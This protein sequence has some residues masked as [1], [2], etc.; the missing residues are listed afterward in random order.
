MCPPFIWTGE[1]PI[2]A[3]LERT[4]EFLLVVTTIYVALKIV[5]I[6]KWCFVQT[7]LQLTYYGTDMEALQ[8]LFES[9]GGGMF[10]R[11]DS[12]FGH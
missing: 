6:A 8:V 4:F 12:L 2:I 1:L 5:L 10:G 9:L 11:G 7:V 3:A